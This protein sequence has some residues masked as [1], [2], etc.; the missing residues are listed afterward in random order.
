M[1]GNNGE[2]V[3]KKVLAPFIYLRRDRKQ[4]SYIHQ[5][6]KELRDEGFAEKGKGVSLLR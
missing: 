4:S 6:T 1:V 5:G 2:A 3:A